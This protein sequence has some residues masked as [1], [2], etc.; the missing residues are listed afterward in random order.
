MKRCIVVT[1]NE[2]KWREIESILAPFMPV[3]RR[4]IDLIERQ[5]TLTEIVTAKAV[6]AFMQTNQP[7]LVEDVSLE[8]DALSGFPGP[9]VKDFL[10]KVPLKHINYLS[11]SFG[12]HRICAHCAFAFAPSADPAECKVF[13][14]TTEGQVVPARGSN[15]FGFDPIFEVEVDGKHQTFAEMPTECKNTLSHR[16]RALEK[17]K[18]YFAAQAQSSGSA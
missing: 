14:G 6:A 9:Y 4:A 17:V 7:C 2:N 3:E 11:D 18:A 15:G 1:G 13:I 16:G 12:Q 10:K 5:G 8:I